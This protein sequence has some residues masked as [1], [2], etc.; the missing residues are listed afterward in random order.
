M[1]IKENYQDQKENLRHI[2]VIWDALVA[3]NADGLGMCDELRSELMESTWPGVIINLIVK[4]FDAVFR[5]LLFND[6]EV[7]LRE[8]K[9]VAGLQWGA[10]DGIEIIDSKIYDPTELD[11]SRGML[12][13]LDQFWMRLECNGAL[14]RY[15]V[16]YLWYLIWHPGT[17]CFAPDTNRQLSG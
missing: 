10:V 12:E 13:A 6:L 1:L 9:N 7:P 14:E 15:S 3:A 4:D 11:T 16:D 8:E 5:S 17:C 2:I